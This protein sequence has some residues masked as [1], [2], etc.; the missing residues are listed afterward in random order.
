MLFE[1]RRPPAGLFSD[2]F[3]ES[4]AA[5]AFGDAANLA[6]L[7]STPGLRGLHHRAAER[8]PIGRHEAHAATA[9]GD[10]AHASHPMAYPRDIGATLTDAPAR[11]PLRWR[12]G[13]P[14]GWRGE[15]ARRAR[16]S[17]P[18]TRG[19]EPDD[20]SAPYR[21]H[22]SHREH[23]R[24]QHALHG[25]GNT[26]SRRRA[27]RWKAAEERRRAPPPQW[28]SPLERPSAEPAAT[29]EPGLE[30]S[31][32]S[33]W[34]VSPL[35]TSADTA[36]AAPPYETPLKD[37][38]LIE[39][40]AL[41]DGQRAECDSQRESSAQRHR[42]LEEFDAAQRQL[43]DTMMGAQRQRLIEVITLEEADLRHRHT[44]QREAQERD[45]L[46]L[47]QAA[48][49]RGSLL[50]RPAAAD[51]TAPG[52][53]A[54][55]E[56]SF[57]VISMRRAL[58]ALR[59]AA[60]RSGR[61]QEARL[62]AE[63]GPPRLADLNDDC[64]GA[65]VLHAARA[66]EVDEADLADHEA[67]IRRAL[68][69]IYC[70][71]ARIGALCTAMH[72]AAT[73]ELMVRRAAQG[74]AYHHLDYTRATCAA[75]HEDGLA[76]T[77][78]L[79]LRESLSSARTFERLARHREIEA[80]MVT[81]GRIF[82]RRREAATTI[83][84]SLVNS[85][86]SYEPEGG[87]A[88]ERTSLWIQGPDPNADTISVYAALDA[89]LA[90]II[91][92]PRLDEVRV[93]LDGGRLD[94]YETPR[95]L[96]LNMED[97]DPLLQLCFEQIGGGDPGTHAPEQGADREAAR[98]AARA[99]G[100]WE[101]LLEAVRAHGNPYA[102]EEADGAL[103]DGAA[104]G[105]AL[106]AAAML[107]EAM[108]RARPNA[109]SE[110]ALHAHA[111]TQVYDVSTN[112]ACRAAGTR[113]RTVRTAALEIRDLIHRAEHTGP[114]TA[115]ELAHQASVGTS[116]L[117]RTCRG[118]EGC[119]RP[120]CGECDACLDRKTGARTLRRK[121]RDRAC[122]PVKGGHAPP[123]EPIEGRRTAPLDGAPATAGA[124][125]ARASAPIERN[126]PPERCPRWLLGGCAGCNTPDCGA[127]KYCRDKSKFGGF[128]TLR[129]KCE[130]RRCLGPLTH[131]MLTFAQGGQDEAHSAA[132]GPPHTAPRPPPPPPSPPAG[133]SSSTPTSSSSEGS[134]ASF[135]MR[136]R[137]V[138]FKTG[139]SPQYQLT[140]PRPG[141]C[142]WMHY[143]QG[144]SRPLVCTKDPHCHGCWQLWRATAK[145]ERLRYPDP[146]T[147]AQSQGVPN[148]VAAASLAAPFLLT[149][150]RDG[151]GRTLRLGEA[152]LFTVANA[153]RGGTREVVASRLQC[154]G[155]YVGDTLRRSPAHRAR[156]EITHDEGS[157]AVAILDHVLCAANNP[158]GIALLCEGGWVNAFLRI[159][160]LHVAD[161]TAEGRVIHAAGAFAAEDIFQETEIRIVYD[162][163]RGSYN[164][165]RLALGYQPDERD[166]R[167][168]SDFSSSEIASLPDQVWE[169][170][171]PESLAL[172][173]RY[174]GVEDYGALAP[175]RNITR[176]RGQEP[177]DF[178]AAARPH[179]HE[180]YASAIHATSAGRRARY[181][182]RSRTLDSNQVLRPLEGEFLEQSLGRHVPTT[183][184]GDAVDSVCPQCGNA[185]ATNSAGESLTLCEKHLLEGGGRPHRSRAD[186]Q[187]DT[188]DT[189]CRQCG[190]FDEWVKS[191]SL[192]RDHYLPSTSNSPPL[193][194]LPE[195]HATELEPGA[196]VG[197]TPPER[198]ADP[199]EPEPDDEEAETHR[200]WDAQRA[201]DERYVF[202]ADTVSEIASLQPTT[203]PAV[204]GTGPPT[205]AATGG[206]HP[207]F[208]VP[209]GTS[210]PDDEREV[211]R[212]ARFGLTP[213]AAATVHLSTPMPKSGP[214]LNE[215]IERV[216][217]PPNSIY[218]S[219]APH[220]PR[221]LPALVNPFPNGPDASASGRAYL[222]WISSDRDIDSVA[223]QYGIV[224]PLL[225]AGDDARHFRSQ[226][227]T[228][229]SLV[230]GRLL[231]GVRVQLACGCDPPGSREGETRSEHNCGC[232]GRG[233]AHWLNSV[234]ARRFTDERAAEEA[235]DRDRQPAAPEAPQAHAVASASH[236]PPAAPE[237]PQA[238]AAAGALRRRT[239]ST[240][241][242]DTLLSLPDPAAP[243]P[244]RR[245]SV[246]W[247]PAPPESHD[248][249]D[250]EE[251]LAAL[252]ASASEAE[253]RVLQVFPAFRG[254]EHKCVLHLFAGPQREDGLARA[255]AALGD[256]HA[257]ELDNAK[258][259]AVHDLAD[260]TLQN[261]IIE[262]IELG[263]TRAVLIGTPCESYSTAHN[264]G[265][266]TEE[267]WRTKA[268]PGGRP[269]LSEQQMAYLQHYD[270]LLEFSVRVMEACLRAG[271]PAILENPAPRDDPS[272]RSFWRERSENTVAIWNMECVA[273]LRAQAG[274][275]LALVVAPQCAF[276]PGPHGKVFQKYTGLLCTRLAAEFLS[277]LDLS[278][279]HKKENHDTAAG[280]DEHGNSNSEMSSAYPTLMYLTLAAAL[281]NDAAHPGD[282]DAVRE[283]RV[284]IVTDT[285][286]H[287]KGRVP[288]SE[289]QLP[290][291]YTKIAP[292]PGPPSS[293]APAPASPGAAEPEEDEST[294]TEESRAGQPSQG[295]GPPD[296][297]ATSPTRPRPLTPVEKD[298][299]S[300]IRSS[301]HSRGGTT[302]LPRIALGM[303]PPDGQDTI[304]IIPVRTSA[305]TKDAPLAL[306]PLYSGVFGIP[307]SAHARGGRREAVVDAAAAIISELGVNKDV[308]FLAGEIDALSRGFDN[309][310]GVRVSV[311]VAP[312]DADTLPSESARDGLETDALCSRWSALDPGAE[313][314]VWMT[315]DAL[316]ERASSADGTARYR[317]AAT[318]VAM[319]EAHIRPTPDA[320]SF[321]RSGGRA[322]KHAQAPT[323]KAAPGAIS[324]AER[325][326]RSDAES[327]KLYKLLSSQ[328]ATD[329]P[330]FATFCSGLA[331][332]VGRCSAAQIPEELLGTQLPKAPDDL[333]DRPFR[334]KAQ[335]LTNHP[336]PR[337]AAQEPPEDGW[338]P[339][340][341]E[342]IVM[343]E[344]LERIRDWLR[345]CA[346]W[347]QRGGRESERPAP[348]AYGE[349]SLY[350][351]ARGRRW[352]LRGGPGRISLWREYTEEEC[353]ARTCINLKFAKELFADCADAEFVEFLV[354]GVRFHA[355]LEH[356]IVLQANLLSLYR[357][358]GVSAAAAQADDMVR[359]GFIA[360]FDDLPSVPYRVIPRGVVPKAGTDELRGIADQGAPRKPLY[361]R[362]SSTADRRDTARQPTRAARGACVEALN[363]KCRADPAWDHEDK[364]DLH[365]AAFNGTILQ[366]LADITG[367]STV[368]I[369]LDMSK[370][371]HRMFY[372]ATDLWTTGALIPSNESGG[373]RLA[374]EMAMTMGA[375]PASQIAQR[376]ANAMVQ[377][378]CIEMDALERAAREQE[379]LPPA[380]QLAL[381]RRNASIPPDSYST[382]GR[383]YDLTYYSDDGHAMVVGARRAVRF[384]RAFW[385][386]AGA[387]GLNAPLSRAG[388]Q[389]IGACVIWLGGTLAAG[390]GLVWI[391]KEKVARAALGLRAVLDGRMQVGDYR[392]LVGFLVSV[393]FML[394]DDQSLLNHIFRPLKPNCSPPNEIDSGPA[395]LVQVDELMHPIL[396]RWTRLILNTPG[397]AAMCAVAPQVPAAAAPKHRIRTDAALQGTPRPGLGGCMY[398]LWWAVAIA[399]RP[400]LEHLDI[401][402]L[403]LL[404]A[405]LGIIIYGEFLDGAE[406]IELDTD[407]LATAATLQRRAKT[408]TMQAILDA[409]LDNP[410]YQKVARRL[411]V[412]H[413][414]GAANI[415][416]DAASRGYDETLQAVADALGIVPKRVP[417]SA[418]ASNF[419]SGAL[420]KL[421]ALRPGAGLGST[422]I[423]RGNL[424]MQ[425]DH[426]IAHGAGEPEPMDT[427]PTAAPIQP[428][429]PP[430]RRHTACAPPGGRASP[431]SNRRTTYADGPV[432]RAPGGRATARTPP[433]PARP[434]AQ[435]PKTTMSYAQAV[436]PT[437]MPLPA[438]PSGRDHA[439]STT[440]AHGRGLRAR[441]DS[442]DWHRPR[443]PASPRVER[444]ADPPGSP[445][446]APLQHGPH[447][448][449]DLDEVL[450]RP[451]L[452]GKARQRS[453]LE[454]ARDRLTDQMF[455]RLKSD[456]SEYSLQANDE[457]L[458]WMCEMT[459]GDPDNTPLNTQANLRSNWRHWEKYC[460]WVGPNTDPWRPNIEE[461]NA[462]GVERER[463]LWTA[464]LIWIYRYS[465]K[466]KP[467]NYIRFGDKAGQ[468]QPPQP[469]SALAV[470]RGVRKEH[471]DR[472]RT[473]PSLTLATRRMHELTS[474]Y[475]KLVGPENM[476]TRKRKTLTHEH[477]RGML[478][479]KEG[480]VIPIRKPP[481]R[482]T[483]SATDDQAD[484]AANIRRNGSV[485]TWKSSFGVSCFALFSTL[486][487]TGFRKAE[488]TLGGGEWSKM[489]ISFA[490]LTWRFQGRPD[491]ACPSAQDLFNIRE[492]D[493]AI[494][495]PPPSKCDQQGTKWGN[496]PIWLPY[497]ASASFNAARALARWEL[498]AQV[499]PELRRTT[500]LFCGPIGV[501]SALTEGVCDD[502]F[503]GLLGDVLNDKAAAKEYSVHSFRSF[504]AS[505]MLAAKC[506]DAQIQAA[507]RW[508][509]AE[510][511]AEYKQINA[512]H[513]GE[514]IL[515]SE[516]QKLTGARAADLANDLPRTDDLDLH[517][518]IWNSRMDCR[519][520]A[521]VADRDVG[522]Y[523]LA[524]SIT[525]RA[526]PE[527]PSWL[528]DYLSLVPPADSAEAPAPAAQPAPP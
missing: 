469:K 480:T 248:D 446:S 210:C 231:S 170:F 260:P 9:P 383:L 468:L 406:H 357:D 135:G 198:D 222:D 223:S 283:A 109:A 258:R 219:G 205:P 114:V 157:H 499:R 296:P 460:A 385:T 202:F 31:E 271:I 386:V 331:E 329:S 501:G 380:L 454:R 300:A 89:P 78:L 402:H 387:E 110:R 15:A 1:F 417:L 49:R 99:A 128:G 313:P 350:P 375:T 10:A 124:A 204:H 140:R 264:N 373:L 355:G 453:E 322:R 105:A 335:V 242:E 305:I 58:R 370:W 472:G 11:Q 424:N 507:L 498:R 211:R 382:Q 104:S 401:P 194:P 372:A 287:M 36:A 144:G 485:W 474:S 516:R 527:Q 238:D 236:P 83:L 473:P 142:G 6:D 423:H 56:L 376:F 139:P 298:L 38:L 492:G 307:E 439:T 18:R 295:V 52:M 342:D 411:S 369:A 299:C 27:Q 72:R 162:D 465:M 65:I 513:Y 187:Q 133:T 266:T 470:L 361:T 352:D 136:S 54:T 218:F 484:T 61:A 277:S 163:A 302:K 229:L 395:T 432:R 173:L 167:G 309:T 333:L 314:H 261:A 45:H 504:L 255:L 55:A 112:Q 323:S 64:L 526:E 366:A 127:C 353:Q 119:E 525:G 408:P 91:N 441:F 362:P 152:S 46:S 44:R 175:D 503:H 404:A 240:D 86:P 174:G 237:A 483:L 153:A 317:A 159:V 514:W 318:A 436:S 522:S 199:D 284:E 410:V 452:P 12:T 381:D 354:S 35:A 23:N 311:V 392:R 524:E 221:Y 213:G 325:M 200:V 435:R 463:V 265:A 510:A 464:G 412:S 377:K 327:D 100:L 434:L 20:L 103:M 487:Q 502:V 262:A 151:A 197:L 497:S 477:I 154:L 481:A 391:P 98:L 188:D 42:H 62:P 419:L 437:A 184:E 413:L 429:S 249:H 252:A 444:D 512:E 344:P 420:D 461:L 500:P 21:W 285:T 440:Q 315:L 186:Q 518:A 506:T 343:P 224:G 268:H 379:P 451:P 16:A 359:Q 290:S 396:T 478:S 515:N 230:G 212:R 131:A 149:E 275:E 195:A 169:A 156:C 358:G 25:N 234:A 41:L 63:G 448:Q 490:N 294:D 523:V 348:E 247:A 76:S 467:G 161:G 134:G 40:K 8:P 113:A 53:A 345:R 166:P 145:F 225:V 273:D 115:H 17:K 491:T 43:L 82:V 97:E 120:N 155:I 272:L 29:P 180:A 269:G 209:A 496:S 28:P 102:G 405:G 276:G 87:A 243:R 77:S 449:S 509:S 456:N 303:E 92:Y 340:S 189:C 371:F 332:Q 409:L 116:V 471:L 291:I 517:Q 426:P 320:P 334:H 227:G 421:A 259:D 324:L 216:T 288:V 360:I 24:R 132:G 338:W 206:I 196:G 74:G 22:V 176:E 489:N 279:H 292:T 458:M 398:G 330:S 75:F 48:A 399:E 190:R 69:G 179:T 88:H 73:V 278:C 158:K 482:S 433:S 466:P 457:R 321:V 165:V 389:Q 337:P 328:D 143:C 494:V 263:L 310:S 177:P 50:V 67:Y 428:Y 280:S 368:E 85:H 118:C 79:I 520:E 400:G 316:A 3:S 207:A 203:E 505:S 393:L 138:I 233:I 26:K 438:G 111:I 122:V 130:Q 289:F 431:P 4:H 19:S 193:A 68:F 228:T 94:I 123:A 416:S 241:S 93:L 181:A 443:T 270:R 245:K 374:I 214:A 363:D 407:A 356:Q 39:R 178:M 415:L 121:C 274:Q 378:V 425:G 146:P 246:S 521:A 71:V 150:A 168:P 488:V 365:N 70:W 117:T 403:E 108:G 80:A 475:A 171:T 388:K 349:D 486:A 244:K 308:C 251:L 217:I 239:R 137:P 172:A 293:E 60:E 14:P 220:R 414:F 422:A 267:P 141:Q 495:R 336:R 57:T 160:E 493:Y 96:G 450:K 397:A 394:G 7:R 462:V 164:G 2:Y 442:A 235:A 511:L 479:V 148:H 281:L 90:D 455:D 519:H 106:D 5:T 232:H 125:G 447:S 445:T 528:P 183:E 201:A 81:G 319:A 418:Q 208:G 95:N 256:Y 59:A 253:E 282:A 341:I 326:R 364:D 185:S 107:L 215:R 390:L 427:S 312:C 257:I 13:L 304:I 126:I 476:V 351:R 384:L 101:R 430:A 301:P 32:E 34:P 459:Q 347:H 339:N 346:R 192:C 286:A 66:M 129:Q 254:K 33:G 37:T 508:A 47:R 297:D 182:A 250:D 191:Y 367:E 51:R 226:A 147:K 30:A 306:M 84:A